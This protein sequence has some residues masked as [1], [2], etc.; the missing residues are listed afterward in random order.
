MLDAHRLRFDHSLPEQREL[1]PVALLDAEPQASIPL[2][3][4]VIGVSKHTEWSW[5]G[6]GA[7]STLPE[8]EL[9]LV[10]AYP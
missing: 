1:A 9:M 8:A 3:H 10:L 6:G 7:R 5:L 2:T 4:A